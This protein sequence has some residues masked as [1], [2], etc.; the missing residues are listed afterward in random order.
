MRTNIGPWAEGIMSTVPVRPAESISRRTSR[1][2]EAIKRLQQSH[3]GASMPHHRLNKPGTIDG[4]DIA[5]ECL[6]T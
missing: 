2:D 3:D 1:V 4:L 6:R 5:M